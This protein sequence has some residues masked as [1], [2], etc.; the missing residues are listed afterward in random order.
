M[1]KERE[2]KEARKKKQDEARAKRL[3][4]LFGDQAS[5][6]SDDEEMM[7]KNLD[8]GAATTGIGGLMD[9]VDVHL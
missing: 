6:E 9:K 8:R 4:R 1:R 7:N 3:A 5:E 2:A